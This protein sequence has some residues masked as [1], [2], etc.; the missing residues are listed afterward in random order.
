M[1]LLLLDSTMLE[2]L[3]TRNSLTELCSAFRT[4][5][6]YYK[7]IQESKVCVAQHPGS[8]AGLCR[9]LGKKTK[10][11]KTQRTAQSTVLVCTLLGQG[12]LQTLKF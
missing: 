7:R 12:L 2:T 9:Y 11:G 10:P 8:D 4:N 3:W 6:L 5:H 1:L